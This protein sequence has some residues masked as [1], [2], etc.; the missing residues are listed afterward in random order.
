[1]IFLKTERSG[2]S[3]VESLKRSLSA[4]QNASALLR[5]YGDLG[6]SALAKATP[7]DTGKTAESWNYR[8]TQKNGKILLEWYNTHVVDQRPIAILIQYGHA[9]R[10]HGYVVGR[11]Y[12]NPAMVGIFDNLAAELWK[13]M[14][15]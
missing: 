10:N 7:V 6:V 8:I 1:M 5:K 13:E 9:T 11:D 12:V 14:T 15:R 2:G 4:S 3:I